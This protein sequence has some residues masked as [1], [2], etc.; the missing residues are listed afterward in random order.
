[1]IALVDCHEVQTTMRCPGPVDPKEAW[2]VVVLVWFHVAADC[3]L[4]IVANADA[5]KRK[6][7]MKPDAF[8][9]K[10]PSGF[11]RKASALIVAEDEA[12]KQVAREVRWLHLFLESETGI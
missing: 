9:F 5:V 1:M 12:H 10:Y 6:N 8:V 7:R 3:M 2:H 4:V 11:R